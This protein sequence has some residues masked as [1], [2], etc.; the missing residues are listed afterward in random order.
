MKTK[1][2]IHYLLNTEDY[3]ETKELKNVGVDNYASLLKD[4]Y[5]PYSGW[6]EEMSKKLK[7]DRRKISQELEGGFLRFW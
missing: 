7:Y 5:K 6:F 1:D 2:I 3:D 4:G